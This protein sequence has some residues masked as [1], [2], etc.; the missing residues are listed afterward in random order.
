NLTQL[1]QQT[2]RSLKVPQNRTIPDLVL[3]D[4]ISGP[5][6]AG[7]WSPKVVLPEALLQQ[8]YAEQMRGIL[9]HELAHIARRDQIVVLLQTFIGALFWAHPLVR[10]LNRQLAEAREE[11][12]D[13]F[14]L[15]VTDAPS[16]SRTLLTMAQILNTTQ[17]IPGTVGLFTSR[18]KLEQRIIG[19]LDE[20]RCCVTRLNKRSIVLIS[21]LSAGITSMAAFGTLSLAVAEEATIAPQNKQPD[22]ATGSESSTKQVV[23]DEKAKTDD[24][25]N[26]HFI[27]TGLI[28]DSQGHPIAGAK[29]DVDNSQ[30]HSRHRQSII[31]FPVHKRIMETLTNVDGTFR[32]EFD[33]IWTR[34]MRTSR[35]RPTQFYYRQHPG[36]L[37]IASAP[38]YATEWIT[39]TDAHPAIP[40][41]I[42][43]SKSTAPIRG[44]LV[45]LEGRGLAGITVSVE[46]ICSAEEGA[47]DR[48]LHDLPELR[49]QGLLPSEKMN[50]KSGSDNASIGKYPGASMVTANTPGFPTSILTDQSGRFQISN[51]GADWLLILKIEGPKIAT[52]CI[53]VVARDMQP[54][55][56]R[57]IGYGG[58]VKGTHYG[59]TFTHVTEPGLIV[60]GTVRDQ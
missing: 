20:Q 8:V 24:A 9:I 19:L 40:L 57:P 44:R 27:Y 26:N 17:I 6:A 12:C 49:K 22:Q 34:V 59:A 51:I 33:D 29:V 31:S 5:F 37:I 48:W 47:V 14:V 4:Q 60:E 13:N 36:T 18:W 42:T 23:A 56:A 41:K 53:A 52:E 46:G 55:Q 54:V 2:W 35:V 21:I 32:L 50:K 38:G 7:I 10:L 30:Y 45:D 15:T 11:V 43:L 16:Y 3:S 25:E 28:V 58:P 1:F 39:T